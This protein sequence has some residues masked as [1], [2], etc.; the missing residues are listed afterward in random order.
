MARMNPFNLILAEDGGASFLTNH[1]EVE[2]RPL[3]PGIHGLSNGGFDVPW[4]KTLQ[5]GQAITDWLIVGELDVESLLAALRDEKPAPSP[6]RPELG[7]EPH[8]A[9]VFIRDAVY[10][11][12]CSTV[13]T[14]DRQGRGTIA[15][16]S[17]D[18]D[19]RAAGEVRL[20]FT[21]PPRE[22]PGFSYKADRG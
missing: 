5:V 8:F 20:D 3:T 1:P 2:S 6:R 18:A 9:P 14:V 13:V 15:E 4:P 16:R 17:F 21:W 10:G 22:H 12:R 7:P 19:G 11:T